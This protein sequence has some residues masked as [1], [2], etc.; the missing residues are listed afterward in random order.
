MILAN[1]ILRRPQRTYNSK[2]DE[3][4]LNLV[5]Q[6]LSGEKSRPSIDKVLYLILVKKFS[7]VD[8]TGSIQ[9]LNKDHHDSG[10]F[11]YVH[12]CKLR[13]T[14]IDASVQEKVSR[15]Y[16]YPTATE[17]V[18]VTVKELILAND[19]DILKIINQ[20]FQEIK[21]WLKLEHENIVPLW[22]VTDGFDSLPALI[23]PWLENGSLTGYLQHKHEML[24]DDG[25]FAL[26]RSSSHLPRQADVSL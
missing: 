20:L 1:F 15:Y 24:F 14:E 17:C 25:K 12:P 22:G 4:H 18:D 11:T 8:L 9:R 10:G 6:C 16:Q 7:A 3:V 5:R 21:L 13:L 26:V 2:I 19:P 23:S